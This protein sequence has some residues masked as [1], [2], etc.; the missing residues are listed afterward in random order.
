MFALV[1]CNNFYA[2]CERIFRPDLRHKPLVV[3]SNNDGCV[4]ARSNE[5]KAL[6]INMG[7][8]YF[9]VKAFC[10]EQQVQIFSCNHTLYND[11]SSRIMQIIEESWEAVQAYSIDE[12]FLDL[13]NM[14]EK[15]H[16]IFC[17]NLH[18]KILQETGV[19]TS[20][21]LG[22]TKTLAKAAN[23]LAKKIFKIPVVNIADQLEWLTKIDIAEVWGI[24]RKWHKKLV[25]H[26][27]YTAADLAAIN[28]SIIKQTFNVV[29]MRTAMELRG[30]SCSELEETEKKQS[31]MSSSSF[32]SLQTKYAP[33]AQAV[34]HHCARAYEKMRHQQR[35][36]Q[37]LSVFVRSNRFRQ[38]LPQYYK[39]IDFKLICP[40]DDLRYLTRVAIFCLKKIYQTGI[41][42]QKI[43]VLLNNLMDK[44][45]QQ[46]DLFDQ[47]CDLSATKTEQ[48]LSVLDAVNHK[49]GRHTLY[50][51]AEGTHY[52]IE[53]RQAMKS[54]NY[55]TQW[56]DIPVAFI[57]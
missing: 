7:V 47:P 38:D 29:L 43:G 37:H 21:G 40:T 57:K 1:D 46:K 14:S 52:E 42:Y 49:Y 20:I 53:A 26:G 8:P 22:P 16:T 45:Q 32:G 11:I 6:G 36:T 2:S 54:P 12:A 3:L 23:Y 48:V 33:L 27:I 24:G 18:K 15:T 51:A 19:P 35:I 9:K 34:S 5:A 55:T 31:I 4:I 44:N 17:A 28:P 10:T 50:L 56:S 30:I 41:H 39:K 13:K 25:S